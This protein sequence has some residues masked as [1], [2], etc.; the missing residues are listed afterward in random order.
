MF[1][2]WLFLIF[3]FMRKYIP[4]FS[5]EV[6]FVINALKKYF[7]VNNIQKNFYSL[8]INTRHSAWYICMHWTKTL[9]HIHHSMRSLTFRYLN[10]FTFQSANTTK[11]KA[12]SEW[13]P[14]YWSI[15]QMHRSH[16]Q[17]LT[18]ALCPLRAIILL[19]IVRYLFHN[20]ILHWNNNEIPTITF[21]FLKR[22][23]NI[24]IRFVAGFFISKK[25]YICLYLIVVLCHKALNSN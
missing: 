14:M 18:I 15:L 11:C 1:N 8:C 5:N 6:I 9:S 25:L 7:D 23:Y 21:L 16:Q 4:L 22:T 2:K 19:W 24:Y 3:N 13:H 12:T 10:T 17:T 20:A